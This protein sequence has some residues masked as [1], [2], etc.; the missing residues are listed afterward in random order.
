[1]CVLFVVVGDVACVCVLLFVWVDVVCAC[2][3]YV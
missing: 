2:C 3:C 1:M